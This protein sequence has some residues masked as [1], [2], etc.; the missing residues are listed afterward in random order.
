MKTIVSIAKGTDVASRTRQAVELLGGMSKFICEGDVV[1]IKPNLVV[2]SPPPLT[3]DPIATGEVVKMCFEA[4][5]KEVLVV[6]GGATMI[7][8]QDNFTERDAF[9]LTG[10]K[11]IVEDLGGKSIY[12]DELESVE[13]NVPNG[14]LY[15]KMQLYECMLKADKIISVPVM[16]VHFDTDVT[17]GLKNF[18]GCIADTDKFW[19]F[20]KDD[21]SQKLVDIMRVLKPCLTVIDAG[22]ALEGSGPIY[23][24]SVDMDLTI[25]SGDVV[26]ADVIGTYIMGIDN[27]LDVATN[28]IANHQ[29]IGNGK[30]E[31]IEIVGISPD[32]VRRKFKLPPLALSAVYD[33]VTVIE[34]GVCRS[35]RART[36]WAL[37]VMNDRGDLNGEPITVIVGIDP[38]VP[39]PEE[40]DGKIFV[41]GD[42]ACFFAK[43]LQKAKDGKVAFVRGCPPVPIPAMVKK[44]NQ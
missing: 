13:V 30:M 7:K 6:E 23:G 25:A 42:C 15:K 8:K 27:P 28:R 5:A 32:S 11:K 39:T 44:Y 3:T 2:P 33:N 4:G 34:G 29:K 12:L 18:H 19:K 22:K 16:K 35:C 38:Y 17:L 20:H 26:S 40:I 24:T 21:I 10:T 41:V 37:D 14:V 31:D 36:R 43:S 1:C 9:E